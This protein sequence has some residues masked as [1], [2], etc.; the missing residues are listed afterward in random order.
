MY[1]FGISDIFTEYGAGKKMEH[2]F[3]TITKGSG[4]SAVPPIE[5][6]KRFDNFIKLC[7]K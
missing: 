6:K 1:Y 4:I 7:L 2:L 5:Y 3:K